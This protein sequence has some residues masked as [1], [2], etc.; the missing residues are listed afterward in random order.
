MQ[1]KCKDKCNEKCSGAKKVQKR[2]LHFVP[3]DPQ[4]VVLCRT[5]WVC[6]ATL[7]SN[8]RVVLTSLAEAGRATATVKYCPPHCYLEMSSTQYVHTG[9]SL[10]KSAEDWV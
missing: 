8:Q 4:H 1:N 5:H 3:L 9:M 7:N 2:A 6:S 10:H